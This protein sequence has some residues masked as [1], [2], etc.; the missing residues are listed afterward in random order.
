[1]AEY[2][3]HYTSRFN[4]QNIIA[5]GEIR[6]LRPGGYIFL[7]DK[8]CPVGAEAADA[9]GVGNK[10]VEIC[11]IIPADKVV[12]PYPVGPAKSYRDPRTGQVTRKGGSPEYITSSVIQLDKEV[13]CVSLESP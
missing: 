8:F 10:C 11:F 3:F 7:T 9:I 4:A 12:S 13:R 2:Y 6:P 1:M 5:T